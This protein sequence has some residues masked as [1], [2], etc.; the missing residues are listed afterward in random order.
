[1]TAIKVYGYRDD[2]FN[3]FLFPKHKFAEE[4]RQTLTQKFCDIM[5]KHESE[6]WS[7]EDCMSEVKE[8]LTNKGI[9]FDV[10]SQNEVLSTQIV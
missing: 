4:D 2:F 6:G 10:L 5:L 7:Y 9:E 1:M 3:V 8:W